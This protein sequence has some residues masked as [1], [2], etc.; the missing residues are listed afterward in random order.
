MNHPTETRTEAAWVAL[1]NQAQRALGDGEPK[2]IPP[3]GYVR[4]IHADKS[5]PPGPGWE[6][7]DDAC[8]PRW[9]P[10][11]DHSPSDAMR[12]LNQTNNDQ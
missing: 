3:H 4:G 11:V 10:P 1:H 9:L 12:A 8:P 2:T 6:W 5:T 7:S